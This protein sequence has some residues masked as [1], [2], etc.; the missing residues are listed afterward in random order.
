MT[1]KCSGQCSVGEYNRWRIVVVVEAFRMYR[2]VTRS[3]EDLSSHDARVV[4]ALSATSENSEQSKSTWFH[5]GRQTHHSDNRMD[6]ITNDHTRPSDDKC[7]VMWCYGGPL[8]LRSN[9]KTNAVIARNNI[10]LAKLS[11]AGIF[12]LFRSYRMHEMQNIV[13]DDPVAWASVSLL[14]CQSFCLSVLDPIRRIAILSHSL[15]K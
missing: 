8:W 9:N 12:S 5:G 2:I 7:P 4:I 6:D 11:D 15:L 3:I 14:V 13:I 1:L 10:P